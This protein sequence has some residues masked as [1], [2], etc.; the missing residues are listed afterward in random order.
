MQNTILPCYCRAVCNAC[1]Y[2]TATNLTQNFKH[3]NK[4]LKSESTTQFKVR[5]SSDHFKILVVDT[6]EQRCQP[7]SYL[8]SQES[9]QFSNQEIII[10]FLIFDFLCVGFL[11]FMISILDFF[12]FSIFGLSSAIL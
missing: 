4:Y 1:L 3:L 11:P 9:R 10:N 6:S 7:N 12:S 2:N 8:F 5:R